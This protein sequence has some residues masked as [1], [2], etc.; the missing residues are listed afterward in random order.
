MNITIIGVEPPCPRCRLLHG[1]MLEAVRE[2]GVKADVKKIACS[3]NEAQTFGRIGSAHDIAQWA[4]IDVDWDAV[5]RLA[6]Q[7]WSQALDDML[8]PCKHKADAEGW[9]MTP[10]LLIDGQVACMGYVPTKEYITAAIQSHIGEVRT[11]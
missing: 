8:M 4:G 10:V 3:S 11:E 2:L 6:G 1:L 7:G 5:H 9:L